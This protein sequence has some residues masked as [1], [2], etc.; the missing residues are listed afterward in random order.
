MAQRAGDL[1]LLGD[2][3][4]PRPQLRIGV[5]GDAFDEVGAELSTARSSASVGMTAHWAVIRAMPLQKPIP[6]G[7]SSTM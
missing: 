4:P 3:P 5:G 6:G 1:L 7:L 2:A